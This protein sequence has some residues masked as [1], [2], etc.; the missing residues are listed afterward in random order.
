[1]NI[2]AFGIS[3][4]VMWVLVV[5]WSFVMAMVGVGMAPF[6]V[7]DQIYLGWLTPTAS[8]LVLGIVL[9]IVDGFVGGAIFAWIYNKI[10]K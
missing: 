6:Q 3:C 5:V 8:G 4:A 7:I 2:K 1:M 10:A 9:A